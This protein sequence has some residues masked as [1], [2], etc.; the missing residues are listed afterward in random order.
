M[1][2][3]FRLFFT[4]ALIAIATAAAAQ[5]YNQI[6]EQ[7]NITQRR[8]RAGNFNPHNNDTTTYRMAMGPPDTNAVMVANT[9]MRG[10]RTAALM[11]CM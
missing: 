3:T 11:S 9:I 8:E 6:D 4:I 2:Q 10:K 5:T 7:G 1:R